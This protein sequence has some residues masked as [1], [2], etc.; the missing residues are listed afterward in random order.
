MDPLHTERVG[1]RRR[2]AACSRL[3]HDSK[4][5]GGTQCRLESKACSHWYE[6]SDCWCYHLVTITTW[7]EH[8]S[9]LTVIPTRTHGVC[10]CVCVCV[11]LRVWLSAS[12]LVTPDNAIPLGPWTDS[13]NKHKHTH[14]QRK[15]GLLEHTRSVAE[16]CECMHVVTLFD[17]TTWLLT[18]VCLSVSFF[19]ANQEIPH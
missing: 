5:G 12:H 4:L 2:S 8:P 17:S 15:G 16:Y 11:H 18:D 10:V 6:L 7:T 14:A 3:A 1:G 19:V 9:R 13:S